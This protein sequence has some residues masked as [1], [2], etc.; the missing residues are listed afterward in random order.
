MRDRF[1]PPIRFTAAYRIFDSVVC[2]LAILLQSEFF[3]T[4]ISA[5]ENWNPDV[6]HWSAGMD[7]SMTAVGARPTVLI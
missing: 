1:S 6:C 4:L 5:R 3:N 2:Q 7:C